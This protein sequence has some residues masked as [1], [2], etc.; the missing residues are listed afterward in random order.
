M[1][2]NEQNHEMN[3]EAE[4]ELLESM[5]IRHVDIPVAFCNCEGC[6]QLRTEAEYAHNRQLY[7]K[8]LRHIRKE[9][10]RN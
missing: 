8:I 3:H 4:I 1:I 5:I 10:Q 7:L 2:N 6:Q 9:G